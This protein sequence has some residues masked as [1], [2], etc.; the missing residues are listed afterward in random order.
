MSNQKI[1]VTKV[2]FIMRHCKQELI[3]FDVAITD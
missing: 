3:S 1:K 2:E